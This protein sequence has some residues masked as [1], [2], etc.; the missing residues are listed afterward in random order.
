MLIIPGCRRLCF[1]QT[2][3]E[4]VKPCTFSVRIGELPDVKALAE[5]P[6]VEAD[7]AVGSDWGIYNRVRNTADRS[8]DCS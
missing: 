1:K 5:C 2:R 3:V 4:A 6:E 8:T 7:E